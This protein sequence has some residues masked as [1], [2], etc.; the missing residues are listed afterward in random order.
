ML[1]LLKQDL[2]MYQINIWD[3]KL[4]LLVLH[5]FVSLSVTL[6]T[7]EAWNPEVTVLILFKYENGHQHR[8][9]TLLKP[10]TLL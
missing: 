3:E 5:G 4:H 1:L 2:T 8:T 7:Y 6:A 9:V 10:E